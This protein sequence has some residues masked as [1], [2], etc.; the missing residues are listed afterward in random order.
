MIWKR[1]NFFGLLSFTIV[2]NN[3]CTKLIIFSINKQS[4]CNLKSTKLTF[5]ESN[6]P[7]VHFYNLL[8]DIKTQ[9][10]LSIKG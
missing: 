3:F 10:M 5:T 9:S 4:N 7:I 2:S 6:I 1:A 8:Y